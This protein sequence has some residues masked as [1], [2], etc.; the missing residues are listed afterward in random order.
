[1]PRMK[2]NLLLLLLLTP[3]CLYVF[4]QG[5]FYR[6]IKMGSMH[7]AVNTA[8]TTSSG[9][10]LAGAADSMLYV[11][12]AN[13]SVVT[14][15]A[16]LM[17]Y[18]G[19]AAATG[20]LLNYNN[21]LV[22]SGYMPQQNGNKV[23]CLMAFTPTGDT[24][25]TVTLND[26]L[27]DDFAGGIVQLKDSTYV[28]TGMGPGGV[29]VMHVSKN[30]TPLGGV[31]YGPSLTDHNQKIL[32]LANGGFIIACNNSQPGIGNQP[33]F[34]LLR[35]DNHANLV[36]AGSYPV[37]HGIVVNNFIITTDRQ[38]LVCGQYA[39]SSVAGISRNLM[40]AKISVTGVV[41][42]AKKYTGAQ[43]TAGAFQS[44]VQTADG[45]FA[46]YGSASG[47][48]YNGTDN[49][50]L[51]TDS[52]GNIAWAK[53]Y[54]LAGTDSGVALGAFRKGYTLFGYGYDTTGNY[55]EVIATDTLGN[56]TC[57]Y[58]SVTLQQNAISLTFDTLVLNNTALTGFS[59]M[60]ANLN[61]GSPITD[62]V[63]PAITP[64]PFT[65]HHLLDSINIW[66]YAFNFCGVAP[67][68]H[69]NNWRSLNACGD[70]YSRGILYTGGDTIYNNIT[71][72]L[73]NQLNGWPFY[74]GDSCL[75]GFI[76]EDTLSGK[77]YYLPADSANEILVYNFS[78][79]PGGSMS[80]T[81]PSPFGPGYWE[82]GLYKLSFIDSV[83]IIPGWRKQYHLTCDTC[84]HSNEISWIEGVGNIADAIYPYYRNGQFV[85]GPYE[86]L[87]G[88]QYH[89]DNFITCFE[90]NQKVYFDV[91]AFNL[92]QQAVTNGWGWTVADSCDAAY[93]VG[94]I[95]E[96]SSLSSFTAFPNPASNKV[97]VQLNVAQSAG[98]DIYVK[99]IT[100]KTTTSH[101]QLGRLNTGLHNADIDISNLSPGFY[102][103]ECRTAA[104]SL[105]TKMVKQ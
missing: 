2:K 81:F 29:V 19:S 15:W 100:G 13:D 80:I 83:N 52:L 49:L 78:L 76:R 35:F 92:A 69:G 47:P 90:H 89:L 44:V 96:L 34:R 70:P 61:T 98:F 17:N 86:Q 91:P 14:Q 104:G 9:F 56:T 82:T 63:C 84:A 33:D 20:L 23:Y 54:G 22:A 37:P 77:V 95:N 46:A 42:W 43:L 39:D 16:Q 7:T 50:L 18:T 103:L 11:L 99:D 75:M 94:G 51:K 88:W 36:W 93:P 66:H 57:H 60:Q 8:L 30:S 65:Y 68:P 41:V 72:K 25:K 27:G 48:A 59:S 102:L 74:A 6:T 38:V 101:L 53:T 24:L 73:L 67:P 5:Q 4:S 28:V 55:I 10:Y 87:T 58:D 26:S 85:C 1:M 45:G 31:A 21:K 64:P 62:T 40:L 32:P 97:T 79:Q 3:F 105:Y 12:S 71:Y